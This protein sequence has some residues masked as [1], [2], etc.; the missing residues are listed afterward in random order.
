MLTWPCAEWHQ[1]PLTQPWTR[2]AWIRPLAMAYTF[3]LLSRRSLGLHTLCVASSPASSAVSIVVLASRPQS[4][5]AQ[6]QERHLLEN[7]SRRTQLK[8]CIQLD[9]RSHLQ[10]MISPALSLTQAVLNRSSS[11]RLCAFEW[12]PAGSFCANYTARHLHGRS[13]SPIGV[14]TWCGLPAR[15]CPRA[16]FDA[17]DDVKL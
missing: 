10:Q 12:Q 11:L 16:H 13:V 2:S 8:M 9:F 14:G 5:A 3:K 15:V 4:S 7:L 17:E 1:L 6:G